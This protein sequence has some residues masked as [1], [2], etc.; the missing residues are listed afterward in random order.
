LVWVVV[1]DAAGTVLHEERYTSDV[2]DRRA[3]LGNTAEM[4][5]WTQVI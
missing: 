2:L 1:K 5:F 4:R 3:R